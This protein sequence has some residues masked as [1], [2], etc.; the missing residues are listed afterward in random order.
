M[1]NGS[2]NPDVNQPLPDKK[3]FHPGKA[4][5][6]N[7]SEGGRSNINTPTAPGRGKRNK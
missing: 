6:D 1:S 5:A 2:Y 4:Q 3:P 7:S